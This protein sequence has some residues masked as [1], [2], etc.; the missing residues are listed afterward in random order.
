ME[1]NEFLSIAVVGGLLSLVIEWVTNKYETRPN[2]SKAITLL[3]AIVVGGVY[4][5][6][7]STAFFPTVIMVLGSA[8]IVYSFFIKKSPETTPLG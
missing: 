6:L 4:V 7:R 8:S 5:W 2:A 3:L 1:V